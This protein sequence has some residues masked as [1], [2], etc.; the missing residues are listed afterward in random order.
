MEYFASMGSGIVLCR[1]SQV[2]GY[3]MRAEVLSRT[4]FDPPI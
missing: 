3:K 2:A 4:V 1:C